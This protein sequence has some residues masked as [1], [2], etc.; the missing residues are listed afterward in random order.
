MT[1]TLDSVRPMTADVEVD[2]VML[3][4]A[5]QKKGRLHEESIELLKQCGL[6][7][8]Q[9][10]NALVARVKNYPIK[11]LF[12]R[13][14]DVPLLV[15]E[16]VCDLGIVGDNVLQ[17]LSCSLKATLCESVRPLQFGACKLAIA[18]PNASSI[19]DIRDLNNKRI[20]TSYP[21]I[22]KRFLN[23]YQI[24][25]D[26]V[27][28]SGSVEIAPRLNMA[29]AICD[30]VATGRTLMEHSL[31]VLTDVLASE[32]VLIKTPRPF[33]KGQDAL[34]QRLLQRID[35]ALRARESKYILFHAPKSALPRI[36]RLLPGRE[37]PTI[38]PLAGSDDRVA[39]HVVSREGVFWETIEN[40]KQAGASSVLVLPI[41]KMLA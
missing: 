16:G 2:N 37:A 7:C 29:D 33:S 4:I 22:T 32:A 1:E 14:D 41:E 35:G 18:V 11:I 13:D 5:I 34:Y 19:Q 28:M 24:E 15:N 27:M 20:A 25:S 9:D 8:Y 17:E 30:L 23:Q 6:S 39:I 26:V 21:K 38:L 40:L 12:V 36:E 3:S 31:R 10:K